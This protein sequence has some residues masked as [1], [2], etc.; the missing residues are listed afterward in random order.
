VIGEWL[1]SLSF[2]GALSPRDLSAVLD[3]AAR[4]LPRRAPLAFATE[5]YLARRA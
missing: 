1:R 3:A 2:L 4:E 5:V